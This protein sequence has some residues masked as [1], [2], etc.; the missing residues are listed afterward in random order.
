MANPQRVNVYIES[1]WLVSPYV[2][3]YKFF[4]YLFIAFKIEY[5]VL[6]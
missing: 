3:V 4:K 6:A 2:L 1:C 5:T